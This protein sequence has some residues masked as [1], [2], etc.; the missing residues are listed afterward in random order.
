MEL[1]LMFAC[2]GQ[3]RANLLSFDQCKPYGASH[4]LAKIRR[5]RPCDQITIALPLKHL[6]QTVQ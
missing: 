1:P 2:L 5:S 4:V 6:I 3:R